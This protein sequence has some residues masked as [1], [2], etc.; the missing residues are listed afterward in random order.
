MYVHNL[1]TL[2]E[3]RSLGMP[4]AAADEDLR[5]IRG[6]PRV[7]QISEDVMQSRKS[8]ASALI[9]YNAARG[10]HRKLDWDDALWG[11]SSAA[12]R[13]FLCRGLT[14]APGPSDLLNH[15]V[16]PNVEFHCSADHSGIPGDLVFSAKRHIKAGDELTVSYWDLNEKG[17]PIPSA[18]HT[19]TAYGLFEGAKEEHWSDADC[20]AIR[21]AHLEVSPGAWTP[22]GAHMG[23]FL[24]TIGELTNQ[25]CSYVPDSE[26]PPVASLAQPSIPAPKPASNGL[27][28]VHSAAPSTAAL[29]TAKASFLAS[30]SHDKE[31]TTLAALAHGI[32]CGRNNSSFL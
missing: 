5:R 30:A 18:Q 17:R 28:N 14:L 4:L 9:N 22:P 15:S 3:Y 26:A 23:Q 27:K 20:K 11:L 25:N 32:H 7:G 1:P 19:V 31:N 10:V 13:A 8:L 2:E 24:R 6:L 16:E 12:S 21:A 29:R